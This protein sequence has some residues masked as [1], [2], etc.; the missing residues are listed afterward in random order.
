MINTASIGEALEDARKVQDLLTK[1]IIVER[2]LGISA[3]KKRQTFNM[4][5]A[6]KESEQ[7]AVYDAR[8]TKYTESALSRKIRC[9]WSDKY[10]ELEDE[11]DFAELDYEAAKSLRFSLFQRKD[12]ITEF[13][14]HLTY[15]ID[16]DSC[17]LKNQEF[18][19]ALA[20]MIKS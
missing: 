7:K 1:L 8:G 3:K 11:A 5:I 9:D 19:R 14:K 4:F 12:I 16:H 17:I 18:H 20:G 13:I 2:D 6:R 10:I 15:N